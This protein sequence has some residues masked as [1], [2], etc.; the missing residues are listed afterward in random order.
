MRFILQWNCRGI[1][2]NYQ[3]LQ[4]TIRWRS[5]AVICL[6]ETKLAPT[7]TCN[8]KGYAVYRK[9]VQTDTIAHGGVMLAVHHGVP[10]RRLTIQ[11]TLQAVAARVHVADRE[12]T[13]CSL[14]LPPGEAFPGTELRQLVQEL[15]SPVLVVGDFNAHS[16]VWGCNTTGTRGRLL[17]SIITDES[18]CVLNTG[19]RTHFTLP[20]G[21]TSVLDLSLTSPQL[22]I[23][24][25]WSVHDDPLGSD[26]F[27]EWLQ[28]QNSPVL[29]SR[30]RKWNMARADWNGFQTMLE[31][32][33]PRQTETTM[34]AEQFS[35]M[36]LDC[37]EKCI[38]RTSGLPRRPPVPWWTSACGEAIRARK[39][40]YRKFDRSSTTENLIAFRKAR[41]FARRTVKEA[42]AA[43]WRSYVNTINRYTPLGDVWNRIKRIAGQYNSTPLPV[44]QIGNR[45]TCQPQQVANEIALAFSKRSE[46]ANID[47]QFERFRARCERSDVDFSTG[48]NLSYNEPFSLHEL[49]AAISALKNTAEGP[50]GIHNEMLRHLPDCSLQALL[51][52][53]NSLWQKGEFPESWRE[54]IVIP[55][56]KPDKSGLDP[57]HYRPISLTSSVCKLFEKMV[58]KRLCWFLEQQGVFTNAQCG[59]RQHRS[60]VDHLLTLDTSVRVAFEKSRHVGAV[61]F[62]IEAAYDTAWRHGILLKLLRHGIKGSMGIFLKNF[63]SDRHFKVRVGNCLSDDFTQINGVPQGGVLSVPLF[64]V[65]VN[66]IGDAL[67][68]SVGRSLFVDDFAIWLSA[69]STRYMERQLQLAIAT[70]EKWSMYNGFRFSTSKTVAVHFCR[71]RRHCPDME[72]RL[73][74][75]QIPVQPAAKF[76]GVMLDNRLT[77]KQHIKG[78]RDKC[79][80]SLNVLKCVARTSYGADRSTLLLLYRSLI[81]SKLDYASFV[82]DSSCQSNKKPLDTIHHAAIRIVTGAFRTTPIESLLVEVNEPPLDQRRQLLGMRY[83]MKLRQLPSH[84]TYDS[85]FSSDVLATFRDRPT[86]RYVPFCLRMR[87]LISDCGLRMREIMRL[88][89]LSS[90][91]WQLLPPSIDVS[92]SET[93]KGD[94]HPDEFKSR[95]LEHIASYTG[96]TISYTDGSKSDGGVGSAFV[97]GDDTR[98]FTLPTHASVF[99]SELVAIIKVLCF[100]EVS[101]EALH[102]ILTD[103]LSSL[104]ALT[105]FYPFNPLVQN[106]LKRITTLD[107]AGKQV[108][109]CWI[110]SHIGIAGNEKADAAAKR[111]AQRSCTRR[112]PL[113]ARDFYPAISA[114]LQ[115]RW[116]ERWDRF[117]CSKL[118]AIKPKLGFWQSSTRKKR[119][120]EVK[121]CRLRNGHTYATHMYLL[122][123]EEPPRCARC[124][125]NLTVKHVLDSCQMFSA[126][127]TRF[128][129]SN[130]VSLRDLLGDTSDHISQVFRFLE[131][132]GFDII[133]SPN[134]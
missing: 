18:L 37:A 98:S 63:L 32:S 128:F 4:S 25:K 108:T 48:Q 81:R 71:R 19:E 15:P 112:C 117:H 66:D 49:R 78:L 132:I 77:Y 14:Y 122:R 97:C 130:N 101:R 107:E 68:Q 34:S 126:E 124:R 86:R 5:P 41:A 92:L 23:L 103:S 3:D 56:L 58:S 106:I 28:F 42:K 94:V 30:P 39:R 20:S 26:H 8:I 11:S 113:P 52:V 31:E 51:A 109:L 119:V 133:Y 44:L 80:R 7:T 33:L 84:P 79:F 85:V 16:T 59:F 123:G 46:G 22:S 102:L 115:H 129:G 9:D 60:T 127:R 55:I 121:L 24:F 93:K 100:I 125:D 88:E 61:F 50:D 118:K 120:E 91:P 64:G 17:E 89:H 111:A 75:Q 70:L 74:G 10:A 96:H 134:P 104:L 105:G 90:P 6:Q 65:M 29:G 13:I 110:P 2:S 99:T 95:A 62:D 83:A 76:L 69:S 67:P 116:Q 27:P 1:K 82:Y 131:H 114:F 47:P 40:A 45:D 87:A 72:I 36:L 12:I 73:H 43:S 53:F 35:S 21:Q 38:P 57:L 54:A